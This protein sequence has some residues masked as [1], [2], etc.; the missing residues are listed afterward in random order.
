MFC[1]NC[2]QPLTLYSAPLSKDSNRGD[3]Y[4]HECKTCKS[5]WHVHLTGGHI[6]AIAT[7]Q[8]GVFAIQ[9]KDNLK[10]ELQA[11]IATL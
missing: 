3:W 9:V 1:P 7:D 10:T 5:F 2:G 11:R 4:T 6:S 8:A